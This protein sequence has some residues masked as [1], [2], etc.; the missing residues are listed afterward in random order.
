MRRK[1]LQSA[2]VLITLTALF[3]LT[4]WFVRNASCKLEAPRVDVVPP[5]VYIGQQVLVNANITVGYG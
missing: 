5:E 2:T 4:Q 1:V 3:S